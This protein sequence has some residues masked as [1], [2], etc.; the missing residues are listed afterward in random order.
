MNKNTSGSN[1]NIYNLKVL[2]ENIYPLD[3]WT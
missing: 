3:G 2:N 1:L